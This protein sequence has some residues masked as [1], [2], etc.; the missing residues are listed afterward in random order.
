MTVADVVKVVVAN[1][2]VDDCMLHVVGVVD[3]VVRKDVN[4]VFVVVDGI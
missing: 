3:V 4:N 1:V 2:E